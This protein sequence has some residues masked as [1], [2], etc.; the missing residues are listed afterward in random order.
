MTTPWNKPLPT[1]SGETKP[2]WDS[3]RRGQLVIQICDDCGEYQWYPRGICADC[4]GESV[5]WV[6]SSGRGTVWTYTVT[7]QNR[8][9]GFAEMTPYVLA[10]VELGGGRAD[11]HQHCGLQPP[12]CAHW[13]GG[14][15]DISDGHAANQHSL[16]QAGFISG[17]A[18]RGGQG[19]ATVRR[20]LASLEPAAAR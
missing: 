11:V 14:G 9:T 18:R 2:F 17:A 3:C 20:F 19:M 1:V 8:T 4:W 12:G 5:R 15:G 13:N 6:Q 10:L 16:L 7:Y